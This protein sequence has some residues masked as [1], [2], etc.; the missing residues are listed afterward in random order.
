MEISIRVKDTPNATPAPAANSAGLLVNS[1]KAKTA[2]IDIM[3]SVGR[4]RAANRHFKQAGNIAEHDGFKAPFVGGLPRQIHLTIDPPYE[5]RPERHALAYSGR[6]TRRIEGLRL[7]RLSG[8]G[9]PCTGLVAG[10]IHHSGRRWQ[11]TLTRLR[12]ADL[13]R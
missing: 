13:A 7:W 3:R 11:V 10:M 6:Q 5:V 4:F 12:P 8:A 9:S 2:T 1:Y